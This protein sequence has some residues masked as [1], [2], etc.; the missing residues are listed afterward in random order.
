[1]L[2][3]H[4][5]CLYQYVIQ[6]RYKMVFLIFLGLGML[7][8]D[9]SIVVMQCSLIKEHGIYQ[10]VYSAFVHISMM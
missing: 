4:S 2:I 8:R 6:G 9:T 10:P 5:V 1:M 7:Y 3:D